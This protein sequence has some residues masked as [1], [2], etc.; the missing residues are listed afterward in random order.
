MPFE[1][2]EPRQRLGLDVTLAALGGAATAGLGVLA[3]GAAG[4]RRKRDR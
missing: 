4:V 3:M 1:T 2:Q